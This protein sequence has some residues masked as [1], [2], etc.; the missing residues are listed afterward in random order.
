MGKELS[1]SPLQSV[2]HLEWGSLRINADDGGVYSG[3]Y[4]PAPDN[5]TKPSPVAGMKIAA[6]G[7]IQSKPQETAF[8]T[9][10]N[11]T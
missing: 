6:A 9:K 8:R 10:L 3:Y 4:R 11:V 2:Q 5:L 1:Y 7:P